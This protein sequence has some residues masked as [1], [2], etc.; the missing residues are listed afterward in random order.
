MQLQCASDDTGR[1]FGGVGSECQRSRARSAGVRA[2]GPSPVPTTD[3]RAQSN[4]S[5]T[6][7]HRDDLTP[8]TDR[9]MAIDGHAGDP[10]HL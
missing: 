3:G 10:F 4:A 6:S 5:R 2:G 7:H 1:W 8:T 9:S